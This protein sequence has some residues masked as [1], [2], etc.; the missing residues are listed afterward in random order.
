MSFPGTVDKV[1][2]Y[3]LL[4]DKGYITDDKKMALWIKNWKNNVSGGIRYLNNISDVE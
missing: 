4:S 2:L 1:G 3:E